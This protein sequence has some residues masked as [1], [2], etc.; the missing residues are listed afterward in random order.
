VS[1]QEKPLP[2]APN[3]EPNRPKPAV[4]SVAPSSGQPRFDLRAAFIARQQQ[5]LADLGLSRTV[6]D[7]PGTLGD[8]T[9][10]D[11]VGML[12]DVLPQRY[13]VSRAFVVDAKERRSE[14]LDVVIHDRHFSPLLF[15][16][17]G[18]RF[19]PAEG[20][21]A[22]FE[23]KQQ[24]NK[25]QVEYVGNKIASVRRLN[26]TSAPIPYAGASISH[27]RCH[28]SL[29]ASSRWTATGHLCSA[30]RSGEYSPHATRTRRSTSD[31]SCGTALSR[32]LTRR[33]RAASQQATARRPSS[34]SRCG[35][36]SGFRRW[37][38]SPRSTLTPTQRP[39]GPDHE[40]GRTPATI[41]ACAAHEMEHLCQASLIPRVT[42]A[43]AADPI[44]R[45]VTGIVLNRSRITPSSRAMTS[46][47]SN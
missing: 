31:A 12:Q 28:G 11:W 33:N 44:V 18:A 4:D 26:R 5:L 47:D 2:S 29:A 20:V 16:V 9:E 15:E 7:H 27:G 1:N 17:G 24:I 25:D 21:Y 22:V 19:I 34:S 41:P 36:S 42:R 39:S 10:L 46:N 23:V 32:C 3:G 43:A 35:F 13:G 8:A 37:R 6:A 38:P 30:S 40:A 45:F 14:Q